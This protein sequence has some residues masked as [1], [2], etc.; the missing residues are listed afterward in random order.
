M[1]LSMSI[2]ESFLAL[3]EQLTK[4]AS[5]AKP[6]AVVSS[7]VAEKAFLAL[8]EVERTKDELMDTLLE[9]NRLGD[10]RGRAFNQDA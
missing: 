2:S 10:L 3:D 4:V 9:Q 6:H 8:T 7:K 5:S 1:S